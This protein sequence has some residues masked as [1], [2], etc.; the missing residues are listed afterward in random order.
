MGAGF[1]YADAE[2]KPYVPFPHT[3]GAIG[4]DAQNSVSKKYF[5]PLCK[6]LELAKS[7]KNF[8]FERCRTPFLGF[9]HTP[10]LPVESD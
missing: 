9:P 1:F 4:N 6:F 3:F 7:S 5:A 2:K 10:F 8:L